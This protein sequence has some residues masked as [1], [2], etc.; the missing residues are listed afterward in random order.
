MRRSMILLAVI[1]LVGASS[2]QSQTLR[3]GAQGQKALLFNFVGLNALNLGAYSTYVNQSAGI[4]AKYF[5]SD[6]VAVRGLLLFGINN[7]TTSTTPEVSDNK[8]SFG[9]GGA[10]EYHLPISSSVSPYVGGGLQFMTS[11]ETTNPASFKT[12]QSMFGVGALM[13]VEYFFN[14]SIS[15]GAEYQFGLTTGSA[16]A[17]GAA[18]QSQLTVGFQTAGLTMAV[19]F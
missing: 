1:F 9:I 6:G 14:Q 11:T 7:H 13:G 15:L 17:T 5:L 18:D 2:V 12:T 8:F 19:Y 4:G 10:L 16:T 3:V